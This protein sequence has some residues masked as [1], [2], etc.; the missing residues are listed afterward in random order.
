MRR[1]CCILDDEFSLAISSRCFAARGLSGDWKSGRA[2][3][4]RTRL[5]ALFSS[6]EPQLAATEHAEYSTRFPLVKCL[7]HELG[8]ANVHGPP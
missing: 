6:P 4:S 7:E 5:V 1:P 2:G 8:K 3:G